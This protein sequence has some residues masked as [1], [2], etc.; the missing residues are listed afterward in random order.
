M[1]PETVS[2]STTCITSPSLSISLH[3]HITKSGDDADDDTHPEAGG[4]GDADG[5]RGHGSRTNN[6]ERHYPETTSSLATC[7]RIS[8]EERTEKCRWSRDDDDGDSACG[9]RTPRGDLAHRDNWIS[10]RG[11][12]EELLVKCGRDLCGMCNSSQ[13]F[14]FKSAQTTALRKVWNYTQRINQKKKK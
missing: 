3:Q 8:V 1:L 12:D 4:H 6:S 9:L 2:K 10:E 14:L 11:G 5:V 7:C 13:W